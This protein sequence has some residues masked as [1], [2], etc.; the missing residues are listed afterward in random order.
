MEVLGRSARSCHLGGMT[1]RALLPQEIS[2]IEQLLAAKG[3]Y[4]DRL[5]LILAVS[6]GFRVSELL[7]LQ[8]EQLL[9]PPGGVAKEITIARRDLKGGR[10]RH[11]KAVRSRRVPL[12]ERARAA[13]TDYFASL[14]G[15]PPAGSPVF[16]S[17][18]GIEQSIRR[19]QAHHILK[20]AAREAGIDAS[21]IGCHSARKA[22]ARA[23]HAASGNNLVMTQRLLGH[24]HVNTSAIY[25]ETTESELDAL[26]LGY[27][28]LA[29]PGGTVL[30]PSKAA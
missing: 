7:T 12:N 13:I 22:F 18:K 23:V 17:A 2:R 4:R 30:S 5:F 24:V 26:V 20:E 9:H 6:T 1:T 28:P 8:V 25:I 11:A 15:P 3:R 10:G 16:R 19:C 27:D 21:R 29:E 14:A